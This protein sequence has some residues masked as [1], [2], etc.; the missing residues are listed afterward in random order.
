MVTGQ[1]CTSDNKVIFAAYNRTM[2]TCASFSN[3]LFGVSGNAPKSHADH[4]QCQNLGRSCQLHWM[5]AGW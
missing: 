2:L 1:L 4:S 5:S 3:S